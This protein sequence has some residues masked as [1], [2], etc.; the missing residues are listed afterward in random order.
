MM[1]DVLTVMWKEVRGLSHVRGGRSRFLLTML[2]PVL[3]AVVLPLQSGQVWAEELMPSLLVSFAIPIILVGITIPDS[4]AGERERHTLGT[5]LASRLPDRAI[6]FGKMLT[7]VV[8]AFG[9]TLSVLLVG[10]VVLN[11]GQWSGRLVLYTP[12]V[13]FTN[14]TLAFVMSTLC[15]GTGVLVSMRSQTAQEAAQRLMAIFLVPPLI[16]QVAAMALLNRVREVLQS[17]DAVQVLLVVSGVLAALDILV[18]VLAVARFQRSR[19]ALD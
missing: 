3:L 9:V 17:I 4:F 7:S 14:L 15:A 2:S 5:L 11:V 6:L 16:L 18:F 12:T 10:L 8:F 19:L 1:Q 13:I